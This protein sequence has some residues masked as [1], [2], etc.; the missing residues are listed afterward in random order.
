MDWQVHSFSLPLFAGFS[1]VQNPRIFVS[2]L[3][4]PVVTTLVLSLHCLGKDNRDTFYRI[5]NISVLI[6]GDGPT[7]VCFIIVLF[8]RVVCEYFIEIVNS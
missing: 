5:Y 2:L 8:K 3:P 7:I 1:P 6:L 4:Y